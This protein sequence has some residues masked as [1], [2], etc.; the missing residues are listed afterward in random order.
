MAQELRFRVVVWAYAAWLML[1]LL[2][3]YAIA[4]KRPEFVEQ[5]ALLTGMVPMALQVAL[6]GVDYHG[7]LA[8]FKMWFALLMVVLLS[9]VAS[10]LD[11]ATTTRP[12]E[13]DPIIAAQWVPLAYTLNVMFLAVLGMLVAGCPDRRLMRSIAGAFSVLCAPFLIYINLTGHREWGRLE[14]ND[15]EANWWG[16]MGLTVC[17]TAFARRLGAPGVMAFVAGFWTILAASSREDMLAATASLL[18]AAVVYLGKLRGARLMGAVVAVVVA[19]VLAMILIPQI[20]DAA[21]YVA[22]DVLLLHSSARGLDSGLTGRTAI[23]GAAIDIWARHPLLG[24]GFR[25]N[26]EFLGIS[27][28][29]AY[30]AMLVDT[31]VVGFAWYMAFLGACFVGAIGIRDERTRLLVLTLLVANVVIGFFDRR[32]VNG[33][34][35]YGLLFVMCC[36]VALTEGSRRRVAVA[37]RHALT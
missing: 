20:I 6:L 23:W 28:H 37:L 15:I 7:L 30:L 3:F 5:I 19:L 36:T 2:A 35:A 26:E 29:N 10:D 25:Q 12:I 16:L 9:Y 13:G 8:P 22:N 17:V 34:T 18:V 14:A 33:G 31:G 1:D 4:G 11:P 21:D 32:V 24:V 27:T